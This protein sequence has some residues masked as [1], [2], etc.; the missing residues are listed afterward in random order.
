MLVEAM[1][2]KVQAIVVDS[3][4]GSALDAGGNQA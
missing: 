2:G 4:V 3:D 1:V